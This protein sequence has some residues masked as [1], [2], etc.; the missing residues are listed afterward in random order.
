[1]AWGKRRKDREET[2]QAFQLVTSMRSATL[3]QRSASRLF[4]PLEFAIPTCITSKLR[5][6]CVHISASV[7]SF[8]LPLNSM[9]GKKAKAVRSCWER[10][11]RSIMPPRWILGGTVY[12]VIHAARSKFEESLSWS[13]IRATNKKSKSPNMSC[14]FDFVF[15]RWCARARGIIQNFVQILYI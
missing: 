2:Q 13:Q 10:I 14:R 6:V 4:R 11:T 7:R 9:R 15:L 5:R 12:E 3:L 8:S 1:M